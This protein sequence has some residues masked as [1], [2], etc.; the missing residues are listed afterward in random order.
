MLVLWPLAGIFTAP[1]PDADDNWILRRRHMR[2]RIYKASLLSIYGETF[3]ACFIELII[4]RGLSAVSPT[5]QAGATCAI[6]Q[7]KYVMCQNCSM[8]IYGR[9]YFS[10]EIGTLMKGKMTRV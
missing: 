8:V 5:L 10:L 4:G 6:A 9:N 1:A 3:E 7:C 2:G